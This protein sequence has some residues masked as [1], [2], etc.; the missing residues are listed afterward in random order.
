MEFG[1]ID[2]GTITFVAPL[3]VIGALVVALIVRTS[4]ARPR[5]NAAAEWPSTP[6]TV[7]MSTIQFRRTGTSQHEVP[8][9]V[10]SYTVGQQMFQG[11][12]IR[13]GDELGA[14]R[15]AG[16]AASAAHIV[17]RYPVGAMVQVFFDPANPTVSALER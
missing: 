17:Q 6:G 2:T 5:R 1:G 14:I 11:N 10:Y 3:V 12:R 9:V 13:V 7:L 15:A 8:V 16:T 4:R